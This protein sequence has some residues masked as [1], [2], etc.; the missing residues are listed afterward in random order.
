MKKSEINEQ[1]FVKIVEEEKDLMFRLA[2]NIMQNIADSE[3]VVAESIC[4]AWEKRDSLKDPAKLRN[5]M[6]RITVNLAKN[7]VVI[8]NRTKLVEDCGEYYSSKP[9]EGTNVWELVGELKEKES[10]VIT[11]YYYRGFSVKEIARILH[12]PEGTVKSRL[13]QARKHLKDLM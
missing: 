4:K 2:Y 11:L 13:S 6:L 5:W 3:D 10:T 7:A 12:V 8:R 1:Y 9:D